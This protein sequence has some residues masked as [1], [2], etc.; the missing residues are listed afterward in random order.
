[1]LQLATEISL[2]V[3]TLLPSFHHVPNLHPS[4][5]AWGFWMSF[6]TQKLQGKWSPFSTP[7]TDLRLP[8]LFQ[9]GPGWIFWEGAAASQKIIQKSTKK[10]TPF[11]KL[12]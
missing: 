4:P 10:N 7:Q 9:G 2:L 3:H 1:M 12:T 6:V 8:C 5:Q 11:G